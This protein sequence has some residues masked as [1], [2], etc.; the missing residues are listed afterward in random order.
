[1]S[2]YLDVPD[3]LKKGDSD[4]LLYGGLKV[5]LGRYIVEVG[6]LQRSLEPRSNKSR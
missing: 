4:N 3:V 2:M 6:A 5:R 1:M